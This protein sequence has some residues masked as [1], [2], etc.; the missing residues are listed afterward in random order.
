MVDIFRI[1]TYTNKHDIY[2]AILV[3]VIWPQVSD[4]SSILYDST[5]YTITTLLACNHIE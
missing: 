5:Y 1:Y 4:S 2:F 3:M